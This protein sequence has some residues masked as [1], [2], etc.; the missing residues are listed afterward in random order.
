ML[1]VLEPYLE[2]HYSKMWFL[3]TWLKLACLHHAHVPALEAEAKN[4]E[5]EVE[6][7]HLA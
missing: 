3:T 4:K 2:S 7:S 5:Q 6:H 1:L